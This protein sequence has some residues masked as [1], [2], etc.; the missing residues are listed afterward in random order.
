MGTNRKRTENMDR[1]IC[2]RTREQLEHKLRF[3]L[4]KKNERN[5]RILLGIQQ[6]Q[7]K[8]GGG[9]ILFVLPYFCS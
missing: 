9:K 2:L 7:R 3:A 8:R 4:I 6:Q 1:E 5:R